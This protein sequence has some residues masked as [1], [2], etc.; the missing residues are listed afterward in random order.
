MSINQSDII[1]RADIKYMRDK[2]IRTVDDRNFH[3][4]MKDFTEATIPIF[5]HKHNNCIYGTFEFVYPYYKL[6]L[7]AEAVGLAFWKHSLKPQKLSDYQCDQLFIAAGSKLKLE[8]EKAIMPV[9]ISAWLT[10]D[11]F[12]WHEVDPVYGKDLAYGLVS[13]YPDLIIPLAMFVL[14]IDRY[15]LINFVPP[16]HLDKLAQQAYDEAFL[17]YPVS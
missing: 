17:M 8:Y 10:I 1:Q 7:Y 16:Q 12:R 15:R 14:N 9:A 5:P 2:L 13:R 11:D 3:L 6:M 4:Y